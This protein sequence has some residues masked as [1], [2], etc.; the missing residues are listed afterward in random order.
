MSYTKDQKQEINDA[1]AKLRG[2]TGKR[3]KRLRSQVFSDAQSVLNQ[4][5]ISY[6]PKWMKDEK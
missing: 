3:N 5:G 4:Y 1:K 6:T 2:R